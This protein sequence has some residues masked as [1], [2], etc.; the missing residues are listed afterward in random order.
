MKAITTIRA[1]SSR[2]SYGSLPRPP[3]ENRIKLYGLYKQATEGDVEG[4]MPRPLGFSIEDEGARKKW[5]AWKNEEGLSKTEAKR[6][7]I[8][9]LIDTMKIYAS[10]SIEAR[11]LLEELIYLWDQIR[12]LK[13]SPEAE[14][15]YRPQIQFPPHSPLLS[16]TQS[17]RYST[18]TPLPLASN[19]SALISNKQYRSNLQKMYSHSK[20]NTLMS[21]YIQQQRQNLRLAGSSSRNANVPPSVYSLLDIYRM[22]SRDASGYPDMKSVEQFKNRQDE[23]SPVVSKLVREF[24]NGNS[25]TE[26]QNEGES[27]TSSDAESTTSR[28]KA[29]RLLRIVAWYFLRLLKNLTFS[30]LAILF[31]L[32]FIK[33][34]VV[35]SQTV[36]RN[37]P[38]N[39]TKQNKELVINMTLNVAENKWF[40]RLMRFVN[41]FVG[42]T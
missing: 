31:V 5:D 21:D 2:S 15:E 18:V 25:V 23:I 22:T 40:I 19:N 10:G 29:Y 36:V 32:W 17:D 33:K 27:E 24:W 14:M 41:I 16:Q 1:L 28:R 37:S 35:V 39:L 8:S 4:I 13:L 12:E 3:A 38:N 7:Y 30:V 34:N 11:E 26:K 6:C 42:F 20:K 9:Y